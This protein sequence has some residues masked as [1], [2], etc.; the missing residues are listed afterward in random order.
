MKNMKLRLVF[1]AVLGLLLV[2]EMLYSLTGDVLHELV[3]AL[4]FATIVAHLV[5]TRTW[6][7]SVVR[8]MKARRKL[9]GDQWARVII[10]LLLVIFGAVL[11]VSSVIISNLLWANGGFLSGGVYCFW[12]FVHTASA[13]GLCVVAAVHLLIHWVFVAKVLN[14]SYDPARR[15]AINTAMG[16]V[17][18]VTAVAIGVV[19]L[20]ALAAYGARPMNGEGRRRGAGRNGT[21][22]NR[23]GAPGAEGDLPGDGSNGY[24]DPD[25]GEG[26]AAPS[27][28]E[29]SEEAVPSQRNQRG[30]RRRGTEEGNGFGSSGEGN[31]SNGGSGSNGG[32]GTV[33]ESGSGSG[34]NGGNGGSASDIC[35]LCRKRCSLSAPKCNK[36]YAAGLI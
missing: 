9:S 15:R 1:D 12:S 4:F 2:F 13:Y 24:Y 26:G 14:I 29:G 5:F 10:A 17:A 3:G 18:G 22:S 19:G 11:A 36:P 34:S 31:G 21:G 32:N 6:S 33:P 20:Q 7:R 35:T 25:S 28:P 27:G 16:A 30:Q 8:S 23:E